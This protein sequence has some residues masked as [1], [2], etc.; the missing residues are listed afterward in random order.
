MSMKQLRKIAFAHIRNVQ[1]LPI[2]EL[3]GRLVQ[4]G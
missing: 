4:D 3:G 2:R 1:E